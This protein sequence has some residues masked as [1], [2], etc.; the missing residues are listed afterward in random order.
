M[1][2]DYLRRLLGSGRDGARWL[3]RHSEYP[4]NG[5]LARETLPFSVI[6]TQS[7]PGRLSRVEATVR[8]DAMTLLYRA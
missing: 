2:A 4:G 3:R 1:S 5:I 7:A 6:A 8:G